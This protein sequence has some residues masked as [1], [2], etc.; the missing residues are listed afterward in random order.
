M[1][2]FFPVPL[3]E[4]QPDEQGHLHDVNGHFATVERVAEL[5]KETY[6]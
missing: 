1:E 2:V 3:M 6:K 5:L 4:T